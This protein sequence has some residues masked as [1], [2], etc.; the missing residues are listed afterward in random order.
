MIILLSPAKSLD[1]APASDTDRADARST[2]AAGTQPL[3]GAEAAVLV[4]ELQKMS[5]AQLK[6]LLSVSDALAK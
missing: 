5:L 1:E 6:S 3:F 2:L 4:A